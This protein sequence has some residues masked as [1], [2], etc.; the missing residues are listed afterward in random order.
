MKANLVRSITV[1]TVAA[2]SLTVA[3]C[4]LSRAVKGGVI[5][6]AAG[7]ALGGVIGNRM[8]NTA[9][10]AVAGAAIGG[11]AGAAIGHY[12]DRQA[13]EMAAQLD[14]ANVARVGEGIKVTFGSGVL[15]RTGSADLTAEARGNL[16]EL[17]KILAKYPDTDVLV[18]GHTDSDGS[19]QFNQTLSERRANAVV[20]ALTQNNVPTTRLR[21]VGYGETQPIVANDTPANKAANRRVDLIV[22][23]NEKL[24]A[25]A[26]AGT[27]Q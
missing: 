21:P 7:G 8:G 19:E 10:G 22:L 15:F 6:A 25:D 20:T 17:A 24:K 1:A 4:G 23:A 11:T 12:M 3:G 26:E 9:A 13:A 2:C 27:V 14:S 18:E 5:G 16:V